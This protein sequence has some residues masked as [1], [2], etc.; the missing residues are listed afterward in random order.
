MRCLIASGR[1]CSTPTIS[2]AM[3]R[4]TADAVYHGCI[5]TPVTPAQELN[6]DADGPSTPFALCAHADEA[7]LP[8]SPLSV[9]KPGS[10]RSMT[11]LS[12]RSMTSIRHRPLKADAKL[13]AGFGAIT[14][15]QPNRFGSRIRLP[16]FAD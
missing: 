1:S 14:L 3:H 7:H 10:I 11:S 12:Q 4:K 5:P 8:S 9:T 13:G 2:A 15:V 16:L 6:A